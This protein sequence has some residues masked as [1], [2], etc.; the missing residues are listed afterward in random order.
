MVIYRPVA[1]QLLDCNETSEHSIKSSDKNSNAKTTIPLNLIPDQFYIIDHRPVTNWPQLPP[2][3]LHLDSTPHW[4][5]V[6]QY[7]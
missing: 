2:V 1:P 4:L 6:L 7:Q 3:P 5:T